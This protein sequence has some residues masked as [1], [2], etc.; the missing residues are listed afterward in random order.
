MRF[1]FD[2]VRH[3]QPKYS[4]AHWA[5]LCSL[6]RRLLVKYLVEFCHFQRIAISMNF[7]KPP[8]EASPSM[9]ALA[10]DIITDM[11]L[12]AVK[13]AMLAPLLQD[14]V[15][16]A[17][18]LDPEENIDRAFEFAIAA[19]QVRLPGMEASAIAQAQSRAERLH[20]LR[21]GAGLVALAASLSGIFGVA[22][23]LQTTN[24]QS[25]SHPSHGRNVPA[26]HSQSAWTGDAVDSNTTSGDVTTGSVSYTSTATNTNDIS[27]SN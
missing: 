4:T 12:K 23:T 10:A 22:Q 9:Q 6:N 14:H 24:P 7:G 27:I 25:S 3:A 15:V 18:L 26:S 2:P 21:S 19:M 5:D 1:Q 13:P 16:D 20:K 8:V 11:E 17:I